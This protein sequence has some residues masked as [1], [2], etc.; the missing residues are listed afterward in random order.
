MAPVSDQVNAQRRYLVVLAVVESDC[1]CAVLFAVHVQH[2]DI[3][4]SEDFLHLVWRGRGGKIDVV[5]LL[6]HEKVADCTAGDA[7]LMRVL[8]EEQKKVLKI[9]C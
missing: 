8:F 2:A 3:L 1:D 9:S 6:A 5:W 4:L 7:Q